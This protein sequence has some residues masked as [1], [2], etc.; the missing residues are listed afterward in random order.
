MKE[1]LIT[2]ERMDELLEFLPL[3][4]VP[5][6]DFI[7]KWEGGEKTKDGI[8]KMPYPIYHKDVKRFYRLAGQACWLDYDYG[9]KEAVKMIQDDEF[10]NSATIAD[11][12]TMLT[13][14]VRGER[15]CDGHWGEMLKSGGVVAILKRLKV[16]REQ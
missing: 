11:I 10:I 3:F 13:Y 14:C 9:S 6:M 16:L 4:D 12:K 2:E 1:D 5:E 7:Q 8:I 15:F